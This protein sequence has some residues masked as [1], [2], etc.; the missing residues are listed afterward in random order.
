MRFACQNGCVRN[1][2]AFKSLGRFFDDRAV[3]FAIKFGIAGVLSVFVALSIRLPEPGW[4][5]FTVYVLMIAQYVGAIAEKSVFRLIGTVI[6]GTLGYLLTAALQQQPVVYL[7]LLGLIVAFC[8][9]MFGQS[10]YPYAFLLCGLTLVVVASNGLANPGE[11]WTYA[12][13]RTEE[14]TV[15]ILAAVLVQS[16]LWPRFAR[17]A[18][19]TEAREAFGD[20]HE[21][22][23][24]AAGVI[25]GEARREGATRARDFPARIA[26]LRGLLDFGARESRYFRE[27]IGAY[28]ELTGCLNRIA[29]AI[30]TLG[31]PLPANSLYRTALD[32]PIR[33]LHAAVAKALSELAA[34]RPVDGQGEHVEAAVG[35]LDAALIELR[36]NPQLAA[37]PPTE[38]MALGV[39]LLALNDI[40]ELIR[41]GFETFASLD[42]PAVRAD[43][44]ANFVSPWP[45]PFWIR[46]GIKGAIAVVAALIIEDWLNPPGATLFVLGTWVFTAMNATSPSGKGDQGAFHNVVLGVAVLIP[47]CLLLL[48]VRPFLS[49]YA[50]VNLFLFAWLFSWG[51]LSFFVRGVTIPMQFGMLFSVSVLGLNGQEPISF[52]QVASVFFGNSMALVLAALVQRTIWPSLPQW[53]L[54]DRFLEL[55]GSCRL[56]IET[57]I[58]RLPLWQRTRIALLPGEVRVR[59]R[60]LTP[61]SAPAAKMPDSQPTSQRSNRWSNTSPWAW[62]ASPLSSPNLTPPPVA[63]KS[64]NSR[65]P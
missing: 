42:K 44:I 35:A 9:A 41:K 45:P 40:R 2:P 33:N 13:V 53:E 19:A 7:A 36:A 15:G 5:L 12:L 31:D 26:A 56:I 3:Q 37:V 4:A 8:T 27:R 38:A 28:F 63:R 29:T 59:L 10:R 48:A 61:R 6:G 60:H 51:Y 16:L 30:V 39:H 58:G 50:V 22:F 25:F 32:K 54:R 65:K 24:E 47:A 49:S 20:L 64:G 57:G 11:S 17:E 14:V 52:Q 43:R 1:V 55:L 34:D 46:T 21:S 62:N 18:F 23:V